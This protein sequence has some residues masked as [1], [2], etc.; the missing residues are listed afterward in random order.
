VEVCFG[1]TMCEARVRR[2]SRILKFQVLD[3]KFWN[4]RGLFSR[5]RGD[6]ERNVMDWCLFVCSVLL[7]Y[8]S[9]AVCFLCLCNATHPREILSR[10][11]SRSTG[12]LSSVFGIDEQNP[13]VA[14]RWRIFLDSGVT[15]EARHRPLF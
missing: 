6:E 3:D 10:K 11:E 12:T 2:G 15:V 7:L 14:R 9:S 4:H 8:A 13:L 1:G 5:S